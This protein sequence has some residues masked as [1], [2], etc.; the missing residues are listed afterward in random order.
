LPNLFDTGNV[1][2][3]E[4]ATIVA[5][6]LLQWKR[7]DLGTDYANG[8][9]TLSY[10]ARQ[11]GTPLVILGNPAMA[12]ALGRFSKANSHGHTP[13][14]PQTAYRFGVERQRC[15]LRPSPNDLSCR[16]L[17]AA[18]EL[19]AAPDIVRGY[20]DVKLANVVRYLTEVYVLQSRLGIDVELD[21][22]LAALL[23][24]MEDIRGPASHLEAAE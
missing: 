4:P 13:L 8:S 21:G 7:T 1:P 23:P 24:A 6:D 20:E 19:A 15:G 12:P 14:T 9:Y 22:D 5:G 3:T 10:K 2:T 17:A 11:E 18:T 16:D